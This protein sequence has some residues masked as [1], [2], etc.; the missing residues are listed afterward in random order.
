MNTKELLEFKLVISE[1]QKLERKKTIL[2][3]NLI[4][5]RVRLR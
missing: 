2:Q 5:V 1:Y 3:S 4:N